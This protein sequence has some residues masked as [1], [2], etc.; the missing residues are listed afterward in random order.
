M[1]PAG[2][3]ATAGHCVEVAPDVIDYLRETFVDDAVARGDIPPYERESFLDMV[4][5]ERWQV[6]GEAEGSP[7]KR[8][9]SVIQPQGPDR[10]IDAWTTAAVVDF[11]PFE[12]GDDALLSVSGFEPLKPLVVAKAAPRNGEAVTC[13][14]FPGDFR[15]ATVDRERTQQPSFKSGTVSSVQVQ[16]SGRPTTEIDA[17]MSPGTSG[18]PT[19]NAA[20]EVLGVNSF[21]MNAST[22]AFNFSTD[23]AMLRNFL[24]PSPPSS[25]SRTGQS[26]RVSASAAAN[27]SAAQRAPGRRPIRSIG[28]ETDTAATTAPRASRTGAETLAT[29]GSRSAALCAQPRLRTSTRVRS[30]NFAWGST[31]CCVAASL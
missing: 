5:E 7:P 13:V 1:D 2:L 29:P 19:I 27:R 22:E 8:V 30:V 11:Q 12:D 16:P 14:G 3:I 26:L 9:V 6:E 31:A 4:R 17:G 28:P 25:S 18:G 15:D 21:G 10:I 24:Q 23:T 20:G